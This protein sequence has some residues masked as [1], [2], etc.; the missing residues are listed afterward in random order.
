ML[1]SKLKSQSKKY[2]TKKKKKKRLLTDKRTIPRLPANLTGSESKS[3][4]ESE[5][6]VKYRGPKYL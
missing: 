1:F 2:I 5:G 4:Q 6:L 3:K